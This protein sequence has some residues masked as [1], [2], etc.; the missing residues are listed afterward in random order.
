MQ[1]VRTLIAMMEMDVLTGSAVH[2]FCQYRS[3]GEPSSCLQRGHLLQKHVLQRKEGKGW[4]GGGEENGRESKEKR[5]EGDGR[6]GRRK[7]EK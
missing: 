1:Q 2:V 5:R 6:E 3:L 7:K 4:K